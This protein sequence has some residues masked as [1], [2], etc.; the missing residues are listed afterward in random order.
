VVFGVSVT[1]DVP[2]CKVPAGKELSQGH[3]DEAVNETACELEAVTARVW[4]AEVEFGATKVKLGS[5]GHG[6]LAVCMVTSQVVKVGPVTVRATNT[7]W[8]LPPEA[9]LIMPL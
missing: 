8:V 7:L 6:L 3:A 9:I 5:V 2:V 1:V 4:A